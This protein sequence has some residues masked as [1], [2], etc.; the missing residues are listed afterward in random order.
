[1]KAHNLSQIEWPVGRLA[2]ICILCAAIT[3]PALG[4]TTEASPED[5]VAVTEYGTVTLAVQDTDLAQVL[6]MLSIQSQKN[7]ITS[8]NV[9]ATISANLYDVTFHQALDSILKVNG[10]NYV[11]EGNFVYIYTQEEMD[12]MEQAQRKTESRIF[13]LDN[14]SALDANELIAPLLSEAGKSSF[15]GDVQPGIQPDEGDVGQDNWAFAA[16]L[17]VNDYPDN[18]DQIAK[19][20]HDLDVPPQQV[21]IESTILQTT[22]DESNAF[23]IDFSIVGDVNFSDFTSP[24]AGVTNLLNGDDSANGFQPLDNK[25][26]VGTSTVGNTQGPGGLKIGLVNDDISVFL[27]VLDEVTDSTVL[28]RP[29]IM[30]LN[31]QRAEVLVGARVGY[32]STTATETSTTQTVEFLD[33]GIQL[34]FRPFISREGMI[35]LELAPSVSEASLRTVTDA[36]GL[37]VTIPDELTNEITT[38]VRVKDG[39]TLVLGGLY[40][41]STRISRRQIPLLGDIPIVGAAFR[42]QDDTV[43]RDEIIFLITPT[44]VHDEA[45]WEAGDS[46]LNDT[47]SIRVGARQGLLPFSRDK[48]TDNYNNRAY[49]SYHRGDLDA[50]L[51]WINNSMRS[52]PNQPEIVG[53]RD[54]ILGAKEQ[55][56]DRSVLQR[57]FGHH[58]GRSVQ[59]TTPTGPAVVQYDTTFVPRPASPAG[60]SWTT[61]PTRTESPVGST[62]TPSSPTTSV[63]PATEPFEPMETPEQTATTDEGW[64]PELE[65]GVTTVDPWN[66]QTPDFEDGFD[67][68]PED[69]QTEV[70][71]DDVTAPDAFT[72]ETSEPAFTPESSPQAFTPESSSFEPGSSEG[73]FDPASSSDFVPEATTSTFTPTPAPAPAPAPVTAPMPSATTSVATPSSRQSGSV[74]SQFKMEPF[75]R[76]SETETADAGGHWLPE[77]GSETTITTPRPAI[78]PASGTADATPRGNEISAASPSSSSMPMPMPASQTENDRMVDLFVHEYFSALGLQNL[79]PF[80]DATG[81]DQASVPFATFDDMVETDLVNAENDDRP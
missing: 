28:A 71:T 39:Q 3:A 60:R 1:M 69:S 72:P 4:Q 61:P 35:R 48:N 27:K 8:K 51:Y 63:T 23:G 20:L 57:A 38:N 75:E 73:S 68:F 11:E 62:F 47:E 5:P 10:Y 19:L 67:S 46:I 58:L 33:T 42:G 76:V 37:S 21:L 49:E 22:L 66:E 78:K 53:L 52:Q 12:E 77:L 64:L 17:V 24:L 55:G 36:Q 80:V 59:H 29:K 15:R 26:H 44:I 79:S 34:L 14:L 9:S 7:I 2:S 56:Q 74:D 81:T 13:E 18:L 6:E 30:C 45:L 41:E 32:L 16:M 70:F 40:K 65:D 25:A 31:R 43:D 50:A 54:Q